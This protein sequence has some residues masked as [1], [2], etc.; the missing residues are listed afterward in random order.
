MVLI[1]VLFYN[2]IKNHQKEV[3]TKELPCNPY[4]RQPF[5]E[6]LLDNMK[7]YIRMSRIFKN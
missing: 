1:F 3:K 5:P 6:N 2:Y 7:E 4:D